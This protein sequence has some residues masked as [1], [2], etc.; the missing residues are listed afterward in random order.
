MSHETAPEPLP[1]EQPDGLGEAFMQVAE[2]A[3]AYANA[4]IGVV[5]AKAVARVRIA[6]TGLILGAGAA[7]LAFA[8]LT[9]LVVGAIL[10]LAPVMGTGLATL[11]VV[12]VVL[13][14]AALLGWLAALRLGDAFEPFEPF[15]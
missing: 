3:K 11:V 14:I 15:E 6:R 1:E 12:V 9:A 13:A 4:Q 10:A 5:R 7:A 8:A 2:D